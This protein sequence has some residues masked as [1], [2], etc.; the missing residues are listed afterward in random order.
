MRVPTNLS[1]LLDA[2]PESRRCALNVAVWRRV[3]PGRLVESTGSTK[4][5][6]RPSSTTR[7][8]S[9][10]TALS[11]YRGL[12]TAD[13][14][15]RSLPT[16]LRLE[17]DRLRPRVDDSGTRYPLTIGALLQQGSKL[18]ASDETGAG[19]FGSSVALSADGNTALIGGDED[20]GKVGAAWVFTR[21][22]TAW[23]QQGSKL[24]ASDE[25]GDG[26][27]GDSVALSS[28][29]NT[30]LI[31]G[32]SDSGGV[33]AAWVFTRAGTAWTQQGAKLTASDEIGAAWFGVSVALSSDGNTA[34][35]GGYDD[36]SG[37]YANNNVGAAWV[38]TRAGTAWTQ[39]GAKLTRGNETAAAWFGWSV[40]LSADANTALIGG[41]GDNF[42]V[43]AAWVFTRAGTTWTQQGAKLTASDETGVGG[44]GWSV[45]LSSD[46]NT[47]LIGGW[48]DNSVLG[49]AWVFTR[50]GA[51]WTQQGAKLTAG[52]ETG[53]GVFGQSVVLSSDGN[54]ALIGGFQ[55][56][57][58][59][60][61][62]WVFTR[63]GMTWTQQ[64]S[65]LTAS[66]ETGT[67]FFGTS[68][69]LSADGNTALIGGFGDNFVVGAGGVGAA[70]VFVAIAL[71]RLFGPLR[72]F[73][74][75]VIFPKLPSRFRPP[76]RNPRGGLPAPRPGQ[77]PGPDPGPQ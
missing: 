32:S 62:A 44:F 3:M 71:P 7:A 47:A 54:T 37:Y 65:K 27:F 21:A 6:A 30:A 60:G 40:A 61:A 13:A 73:L 11:R 63:A 46:G 29:G 36:G 57:S 52:D 31:G 51:T 43:G 48:N 59:V 77:G 66:D 72:E 2:D 68:V 42:G 55:D 19:A 34:L 5:S 18:T 16:R 74:Y 4:R 56:N 75:K 39:Q 76:D 58:A 22:G 41:Y 15:D 69:A 25:T 20:N 38:F 67:G 70:W 28:D 1:E 12:S 17:N 53:A 50:L 9:G 10:D 26:E 64:G 23:T 14:A 24:T 35:V 8:A 49:A 45:A 33:G